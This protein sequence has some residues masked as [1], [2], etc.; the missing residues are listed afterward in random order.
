MTKAIYHAIFPSMSTHVSRQK[1]KL[2]WQPLPDGSYYAPS[3]DNFI[4]SPLTITLSI[5]GWTLR[6][7]AK[8]LAL[9]ATLSTAMQKGYDYAFQQP[10][11]QRALAQGLLNRFQPSRKKKKDGMMRAPYSPRKSKLT[12]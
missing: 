4:M 5:D 8:I 7:D 1:L 3:D 10:Q 11:F 9:T 6:D 2:Y 12:Q